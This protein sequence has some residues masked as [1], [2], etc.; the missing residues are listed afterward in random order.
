MFRSIAKVD[1][2]AAQ[3]NVSPMAAKS[4]LLEYSLLTPVPCMY[5][6]HFS[7]HSDGTAYA[8]IWLNTTV[9]GV[10]GTFI[11]LSPPAVSGER[12]YFIAGFKPLHSAPSPPNSLHLRMYAIDVRSI[13]VERIKV[14]WYH[15]MVLSDAELPYLQSLQAECIGTSYPWETPS[16]NVLVED[17]I[18]V[19]TVNYGSQIPPSCHQGACQ[20][21]APASMHSVIMSLTDKG[22]SFQLNFEGKNTP[23]FQAV[24]YASPNFTR[25]KCSPTAPPPAPSVWV[26]YSVNGN[27]QIR[28]IDIKTG[29][30]ISTISIAALQ[31]ITLTSK[32]AIFYNDQVME[33]GSS[34]SEEMLIPLVFGYATKGGDYYIAAVDISPNP[35]ELRWTVK[36]FDNSPPVGQ[37]TTVGKGRDTWMIVTTTQGCF[38]YLLYSDRASHHASL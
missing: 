18:V 34:R 3:S 30:V 2:N 14:A 1:C 8:S 19:A 31:D 26:S 33:C 20:E 5:D 38:F 32:M 13:M 21:S 24:V 10:N 16:G 27:S 29:D 28:N 15:D 17:G 37:I 22:D 9:D 12:V 6:L 35:A 25:S 11:P 4:S 23:P 36:T 7:S